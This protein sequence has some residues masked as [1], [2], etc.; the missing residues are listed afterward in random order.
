MKYTVNKN[1]SVRINLTAAEVPFIT[2][3]LDEGFAGAAF[4]DNEEARRTLSA[5]AFKSYLHMG[6]PSWMG[7]VKR[8]TYQ[9]NSQ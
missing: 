3:V 5:E 8:F 4:E 6:R 2:W 7:M 1:G 9:D